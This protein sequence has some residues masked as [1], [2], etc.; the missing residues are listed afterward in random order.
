MILTYSI[1]ALEESKRK[2]QGLGQSIERGSEG[3]PMNPRL[4][5]KEPSIRSSGAASFSSNAT[6]TPIPKP[7]GTMERDSPP[8]EL[9]SEVDNS[10]VIM[11]LKDETAD[12]WM[13]CSPEKAGVSS[14]G[15]Q[16]AFKEVLRR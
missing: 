13:N 1:I 3:L 6:F 16:S 2:A 8:Q 12:S 14:N 9:L 7:S 11:S 10:P 4:R 15:K 5:P